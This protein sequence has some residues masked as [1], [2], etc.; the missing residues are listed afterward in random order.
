MPTQRIYLQN[1]TFY[2]YL[3]L[4]IAPLS[5]L[6]V[7]HKMP[8]RAVLPVAEGTDGD[9]LFVRMSLCSVRVQVPSDEKEGEEKEESREILWSR[10]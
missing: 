10:K 8:C 1:D 9:F 2:T 5:F 3:L 6:F 4:Y 7:Y